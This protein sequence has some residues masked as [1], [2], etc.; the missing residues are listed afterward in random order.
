[1]D[2][3]EKALP[4]ASLTDPDDHAEEVNSSRE[5]SL[6][7][8]LNLTISREA[9][10]DISDDTA[11]LYTDLA[12]GSPD[13]EGNKRGF[14]NVLATD[15]AVVKRMRSEDNGGERDSRTQAGSQEATEKHSLVQHETYRK[16]VSA[17]VI[18]KQWATLDR[19]SARSFA[20]LCEIS[21]SKVMERFA[22]V[23]GESAKIA[24]ALR[25][26]AQHWLSEQQSRS[27]LARL[28]VTRLPPLKSL[29]VRLRGVKADSFDAL[30]IDLTNHRKA[31]LELH[32]LAELKQ[33]Q[34][35]ESYLQSLENSFLLDQT[36]LNDFKKT[37]ASLHTQIAEEE[38]THKAGFNFDFSTE[39]TTQLRLPR[40][41]VSLPKSPGRKRF[42][43]D[44]DK[45]TR[46]ILQ[47]LN[48]SIKEFTYPK[49]DMR[50]ICD[51]LD[52]IQQH[53]RG[54]VNL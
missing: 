28:N 10:P 46:D 21:M 38:Q 45:D 29:S 26:L 13:S 23:S 4:R 51:G 40:A 32:L 41:P 25:V 42:N 31:L 47:E 9:T 22:G 33:L 8:E 27:F 37:T 15:R 19:Q 53:L 52:V 6:P 48:T 2:E 36:Y 16:R 1:M 14:S 11:S 20:N 43:P 18:D 34:G 49:T 44:E 39:D 5:P 7:P 35:L 30:N 24:E 17:K 3:S 54:S 50:D 12:P